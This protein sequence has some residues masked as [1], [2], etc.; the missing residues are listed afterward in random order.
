MQE[1][2]TRIQYNEGSNERYIFGFTDIPICYMQ[3][4]LP[5]TEFDAI[6]T[7]NWILKFETLNKNF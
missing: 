7:A 5:T 1:R 3:S 4:H 6:Q 2:E